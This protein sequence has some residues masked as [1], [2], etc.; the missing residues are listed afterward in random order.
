MSTGPLASREQKAGSN[1][2]W[3]HHALSALN[4]QHGR[5]VKATKTATH[6]TRYDYWL[7]SARRRGSSAKR[8][9]AAMVRV[10]KSGCAG[11]RR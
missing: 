5:A 8:S 3:G 10:A 2:A 4:A 6:Y 1:P 7:R 11:L 9:R